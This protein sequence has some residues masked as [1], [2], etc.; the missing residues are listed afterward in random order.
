MPLASVAAVVP[1]TFRENS[2]RARR[3]SSGA[4]T[5]VKW[6]PR[7]S[8]TRRRRISSRISVRTSSAQEGSAGEVRPRV[9]DSTYNVGL[10][11]AELIWEPLEQ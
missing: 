8:P 5:E 9:D 7:T 4:T 3:L 10:D 6:R 11:V 1:S 2:S